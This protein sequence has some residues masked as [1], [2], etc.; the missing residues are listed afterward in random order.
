MVIF[1][2]SQVLND[3]FTDDT[4]FDFTNGAAFAQKFFN[5][6]FALGFTSIYID[7]VGERSTEVPLLDL[8]NTS[9]TFEVHFR[10]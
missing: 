6:T 7:P 4:G 2:R 3:V 5:R 9:G 8:N 10:K 1:N